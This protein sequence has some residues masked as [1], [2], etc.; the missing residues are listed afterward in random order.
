MP[1]ICILIFWI[2]LL[3]FSEFS[4]WVEYKRNSGLKFFSRF[5]GLPHPVMAKNNVGKRFFNFLNFFAI[6]LGIF[7]PGRVQTEFGTKIFFSLSRP[8]SSS[9]LQKIMPGRGFIIFWI[10]LLFFWNFLAHVEYERNSGRKFF[11]S[12]F[13]PFSSRFGYK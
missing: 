6:F 11:F 2:F 4:C 12:L 3:Y 5:L 1:E 13:R 7:L 10:F 9:L 8:T